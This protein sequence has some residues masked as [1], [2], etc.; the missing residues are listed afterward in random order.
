MS[1]QKISSQQAELQFKQSVIQAVGEVSDVL[2]QTDK[3]K[4][5]RSIAEALVKRSN[6][7]VKKCGNSI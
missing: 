6:E 3:L 7:T 5:Q 2:V 1:S 4:E